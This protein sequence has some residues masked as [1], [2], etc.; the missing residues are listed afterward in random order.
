MRR[1]SVAV[2]YAVVWIV[3]A[4]M[5]SANAGEAFYIGTW[6]LAGAEAAPWTGSGQMADSVK[7]SRL[8]GK[9]IVFKAGEIAGPAPF[10]CKHPQYKVSDFTPEMIFQGALEEMQSKDKSVQP[11]RIAASLGFSGTSIKTLE[12][13]CEIDFHFIDD[14]TAKASLNDYIYELKKQ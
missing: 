13:G 14:G 1:A 4:A 12:T 8:L 11:S 2:V 3:V 7:R 9:T 5:A 6:K 10:A